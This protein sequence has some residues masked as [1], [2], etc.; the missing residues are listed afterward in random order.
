[1]RKVD[2]FQMLKFSWHFLARQ[3]HTLHHHHKVLDHHSRQ[4]ILDFHSRQIIEAL[5]Q[6]PDLHFNHYHCNHPDRLYK[7]QDPLQAMV[8]ALGLILGKKLQNC[9]IAL[10]PKLR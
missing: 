10:D 4:I 5:A 3:V 6:N 7:V 9:I 2:L 1:M 8:Q